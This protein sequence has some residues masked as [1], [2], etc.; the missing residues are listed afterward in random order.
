[1]AYPSILWRKAE[2]LNLS[3][4]GAKVIKKFSKSIVILKYVCYNLVMTVRVK[5]YAKLNLTLSI[6]GISGGYHM[7]DSLV[8]TVDLHDVILLKKR[9]DKQ[10][11]VRMHGRGTEGMSPAINNAAKAAELFVK[12]FNTNGL[13]V[14]VFKNIPLGAGMGGSSADAAGVLRGA[15]SLYGVGSQIQL[16]RLAEML[17]SDTPYMLRGGYAR[18]FGRG[19][20]VTPVF[21]STRLDLLALVPAEGV[22][23]ARCFE[24]YDS[25]PQTLPSSDG[26]ENAL[27]SGDKKLLGAALSNGLY[28]PAS[29]LNP[30]ITKAVEELKAMSPLGVN[31]TGSGS[32]VFALF[33]NGRQCSRAKRRYK[34]EFECIRL[35]TI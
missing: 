6:N 24:L 4:I 29:V 9:K 22:S 16:T 18:L 13:D 11:T 19:E 5:A 28:T 14:E 12:T 15:S 7:L 3:P 35:K 17:G 21:S 31:M 27:L 25:S 33:E 34:G 1:M 2:I 10:I 26:A 20:K 8:C 30:C 32:A 23:T